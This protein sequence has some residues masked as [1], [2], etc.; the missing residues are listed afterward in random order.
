VKFL[1]I[2][3]PEDTPVVA[4]C[5][6]SSPHFSNSW[7]CQ[8]LT[9]DG[10]ATHPPHPPLVLGHCSDRGVNGVSGDQKNRRNAITH[11]QTWFLKQGDVSKQPTLEVKH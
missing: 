1:V 11:Q 8:K 10:E 4:I 5:Q 7:Q 3:V 6:Q 9:M 2:F